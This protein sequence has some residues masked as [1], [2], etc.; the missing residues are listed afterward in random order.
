MGEEI[1]RRINTKILL[2][3]YWHA[4]KRRK[5]DFEV[6]CS[7][8]EAIFRSLGNFL[9]ALQYVDQNPSM[10]VH[11]KHILMPTFDLKVLALFV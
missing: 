1:C 11:N 10:I 8:R 3:G 6:L 2:L 7:E 5:N 9:C 4:L